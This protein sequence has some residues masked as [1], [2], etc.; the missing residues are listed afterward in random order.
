M[1][2]DQPSSS[3]SQ[4]GTYTNMGR[5]RQKGDSVAL[6]AIRLMRQAVQSAIDHDDVHPETVIACWWKMD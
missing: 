6:E 2:A 1:S 3:D 5:T 4:H